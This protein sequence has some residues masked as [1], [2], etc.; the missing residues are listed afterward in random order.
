MGV[1]DAQRPRYAPRFRTQDP[2]LTHDSPERRLLVAVLTQ[3]CAYAIGHG[4][5][6]PAELAWLRSRAVSVL[7]LSAE[8]VC[9]QLGY[10]RARLYA[11]VCRMRLRGG[12]LAVGPHQVQAHTHRK[13]A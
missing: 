4:R 7:P 12:R 3:A 9:Q 1:S 6:A 11:Q 5:Y 10:D 8:Y 13:A 2:L